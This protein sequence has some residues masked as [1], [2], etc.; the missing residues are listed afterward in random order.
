MIKSNGYTAPRNVRCYNMESQPR[1]LALIINNETFDNDTLPSRTGSVVDANNLDCLFLQLG[2]S[3][4]LRRNLGY[5]DMI[6]EIQKFA[7][8]QELAKVDMVMVA[9][10]SHGRHGLVAAADGR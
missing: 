4:T 5:T 3:V 2:F 6:M 1:G 7:G 10:M 9:I 8:R